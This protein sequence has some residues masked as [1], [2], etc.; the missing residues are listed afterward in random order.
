MFFELDGYKRSK[1][2]NDLS[3]SV[4]VFLVALPLCLGIALASGVPPIYGLIS[5]IIGGLVIGFLTGSPMQVSGPAAGLAVMVFQFVETYGLNSLG[6]IVFASG[7]FQVLFSVFKLGPW[8][9]AVSQS[10][11]KGMLAGIGILIFCSQFHVMLDN[12][13]KASAV[14]NFITIPE[15]IFSIFGDNKPPQH[16][17]AGAMGI[18]TIS[19]ILAWNYLRE[20]IKNPIPAPLFAVLLVTGVSMASGSSINKVEIPADI[21]T[22]LNILSL[23]SLSSFSFSMI[24]AGLTMAIIASTETLLCVNA[25]DEMKP[26]I[27]SRYNQELMAQGVGNLIAGVFGAL[28]ITGVIVR[29]SANVDAGAETRVSAIFHG[30]WLLVMVFFASQYLANIPTA[31]LAALLVY[32]G[33][34]LID[35]KF[36]V[37]IYKRDRFEAG[38]F[39]ATAI[40][41]FATNLLTGVIIGFTLS[42]L[43]LL[44][45]VLNVSIHHEEKDCGTLKVI[46]HGHM[47]F[48]NL[49]SIK[50]ELEK[51]IEQEDSKV[52][53]CLEN[54]VYLDH[55]AEEYID[56][57]KKNKAPDLVI[58]WGSHRS[59]A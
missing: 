27:K 39:Y 33:Y 2:F 3:S 25:V 7:I 37:S 30:L 10:V 53:L 51:L 9:R 42:L 4:V 15:A 16:I 44:F 20:R 13:P 1:F 56:N 24:L 31:A 23:D 6:P 12:A 45:S 52:H 32:T 35:P 8:F 34:R 57:L 18:L 19:A 43:R 14:L 17:I 50:D 11:V 38:I 40:G 5:G 54:V 21:M 36:W 59:F 41:I 48:L 49:P 46:Y 28:P 55:S 26:E 29:S 47:C 22:K 58:E